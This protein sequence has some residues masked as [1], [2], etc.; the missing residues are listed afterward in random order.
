[1][2]VPRFSNVAFA[3]VLLLGATGIGEAV[4]HMPAVNALWETGYGVA[5]LVKAGLLGGAIA[6]ASGNLLRSKPRLAAASERPELGDGASRLL[7]RDRKRRT[8]AGRE[9]C[10]P[11]GI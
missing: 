3:A 8:R 7:L 11:R 2:L 9:D 10:Q 6:I 5:I 4:D 1:M